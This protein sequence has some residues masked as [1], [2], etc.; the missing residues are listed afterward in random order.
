M[1]NDFLVELRELHKH[2][3]LP[4]N[5]PALIH[6]DSR[7]LRA[8]QWFVPIVGA[9]FDGHT[10]IAEVIQKG[11][12]GFF[13]NQDRTHLVPLALLSLGIAVEDTTRALQEL[14]KSWRLSQNQLKVVGITGSSGK[15]TLKEL[16][17]LMLSE[18]GSTLK[19]EG[20]L[21]NELGV[22]LTLCR[23]NKEHKFAV[24]EMGARHIGDIGF[25][26]QFVCQDIGVLAN[27][28]TAHVG[29]FGGVENIL[30]AKMEISQA[31]TCI[32]LRDDERIHKAMSLLPGKTLI[33][34]GQHPESDVRWLDTSFLGTGDIHLRFLIRGQELEGTFPYFHDSFPIN[35][36]CSL[37]IGLGLQIDLNLALKGLQ[38]F[39]GLKGRFQVHRLQDLILIDDAY[40]ANPHSMLSGLETLRKAY[41]AKSKTI[42]LGDMNELGESSEQSH[43]DIGRYCALHFSSDRLITIG[44]QAEW[45]ADQALRD[46]MKAQ[47]ISTYPQVESFLSH[48][49]QQVEGTQLL[50]VKASNSL[51]LNKIIETI[52]SR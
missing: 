32:Y 49:Q 15:T 33:S 11:A 10:Y 21:N 39:A 51:K 43:R 45:I 37:A 35:V 13:Y 44:K 7:T 42:I 19:T 29:E 25:L 46:G 5:L 2:K 14:A 30:K 20:S 36:A 12:L 34:F 31:Q 26:S 22:P 48:L 40:N 24:I 17:S 23:L 50:Y 18:I 6:T 9:N 47:Q 41:S 28:G 4:T 52:L 27:V 8:G 1:A 38:R 3:N 16:S